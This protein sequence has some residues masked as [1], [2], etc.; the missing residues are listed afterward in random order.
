MGGQRDSRGPAIPWMFLTNSWRARWRSLLVLALMVGLIGGAAFAAVA[1]ARRSASS[2][3]R[4]DEAA[5]SRDLFISGADHAPEP[6]DRLLDGPLVEDRLD[7]VFVFAGPDFEENSFFFAPTDADETQVERGVLV[8]GRRADPADPEELVVTEVVARQYDLR[9][10]DT[11]QLRSIAPEQVEAAF[12][13]EITSLDGPLLPMQV[14]G[15]VRTGFDLSV[16]SD[17]PAIVVFTPAFL[18]RYG[19]SVGLGTASH[20]VRLGDSPDAIGEFT[21]AVE[22]AYAGAPP[23][24]SVGVSQGAPLLGDSIDV[25]TAALVALGLVVTATGLMWIVAAVVSQQR[26]A[27]GD[28]EVLRALGSTPTERRMLLIGT[29]VPALLAG[30]LLAEA[31]AVAL[32]PLFPVGLARRFDPD[33]GLHADATVLVLGSLMLLV[34]FGVA[35]AMSAARLVD[36][37]ALRESAPL[38]ASRSL[39]RVARWL[40]PAPATG[41]RFAL[42]AP[43][44]VS[45]PVRPALAAASIGVLGL[46][47]VGV[48][49]ASLD[50]LVETPARWGTNWDVAV[51]SRDGGGD[52][53]SDADSE[54]AQG[55]RDIAAAAVGLFDEQVVVN[56]H[57]TLAMALDPVKG[58]LTPTVVSGREPR[59]D[60][61]VAV[62]HDT[63]DKLGVSLGSTVEISSR[64]STRQQ[65]RLVGVVAFPT[66]EFSFPL[67]DGA[68][69][70]R[71]GGDRLVLGDPKRDYA[72][73]ERLLVRWA[74]G[75]AQDAALR[76]LGDTAT[77]VDRPALSAEL[78]GLRDVR[79]FPAL[80]AAGLA[81]LGVI[82]TTHALAVTVT[83]RG[84]ELG[85]LSVLGFRPRQRRLVIAA[86]ATTLAL[87]A[88]VVGVPLGAVAGRLLWLT[89]AGAIGVATDPALPFALFAVGVPAIVV[90]LNLIGAV[91]GRFAQRLDVAEALRSE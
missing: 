7:L 38:R 77:I 47:G 17:E 33:L 72:G 71:A 43:R 59:A 26:L 81:L 4:L 63:L 49:G 22:Q 80:V 50:R 34:V 9:P 91:P 73:F 62:G 84:T 85:V 76:R 51:A 88:L 75:V 83:R 3:T 48:V 86:Q 1:G 44:T 5:Q 11:W 29:V 10:G 36:R 27:A 40:P 18:E 46:V 68:A 24:P 45:T 70:T 32:S 87:V 82:A 2:P 39:E 65:F 23:Q 14:T 55:N 53:V 21:D 52:E 64:S 16:R 41:V 15:V 78:I 30:V 74:P 31:V 90:V 35:T 67:A 42:F 54:R 69:F 19:D 56:G 13:G 6:L 60:D 57:E 66:I 79:L 28:V 12:E 25:I 61:E 89:I 8:D 20:M 37:A 58:D